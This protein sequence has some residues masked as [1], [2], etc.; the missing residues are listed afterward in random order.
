MVDLREK[1]RNVDTASLRLIGMA[2]RTAAGK[3]TAA[4]MLATAIG[5]RM[6]H[7]D[8]NGIA[9]RTA[10]SLESLVG[11]VRA[12]LILI[13]VHSVDEWALITSSF[14]GRSAL[15]H[16]DCAR[17]IR[18]LRSLGWTERDGDFYRADDWLGGPVDELRHAATW[19]L[20]NDG[21]LRELA[22][23]VSAISA[24]FASV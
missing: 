16:I 24:C 3:A 4:A 13:G 11:G 9:P 22:L 17:E 21:D 15:I 1:L 2:G 14:A 8:Q 12:P 19:C 6:V 7:P 23:Q 18:M 5:W 20:T 10:Q